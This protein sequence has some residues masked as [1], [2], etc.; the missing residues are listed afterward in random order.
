MPI[1]SFIIVICVLILV[2]E[3]GHFLFAKKA[4]VRVDEFGIGF[5]PRIFGKKIGETVYSVNALPFGGFVKIFGEDG[6]ESAEQAGNTRAFSVKP[7]SVQ[8][9]I[10]AAGVLFNFLFAWFLISLGFSFGLPTAVNDRWQNSIQNQRLLITDVLPDSPA[11]KAGLKAGDEILSIGISED[12]SKSGKSYF[13]SLTVDAARKLIAETGGREF[14]ITYGRAGKFDGNFLTAEKGVVGDD[15]YGIGIAM[16]KVGI[17]KLPF[18]S[19][20]T[21]GF[22]ATMNMTVSVFRAITDL[23]GRTLTGHGN[24]SNIAGPVGMINLVAEAQKMGFSYLITFSAMISIN[25]AIINL[26]PFPALDGG[27]LFFLLI[28]KLRGKKLKPA[29]T[30]TLNKIGFG[31]LVALLVAVTYHDIVRLF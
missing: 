10:L 11:E 8:A 3:L 31:L 19:A 5:P 17:L 6:V 4:G 21:E 2:H 24:L 22:R 16:E 26:I 27:R 9:A 29:V 1:I 14:E 7:K 20:I 23:V 13:Q 30:E 15:R 18:Y 28:E 12:A 25:L